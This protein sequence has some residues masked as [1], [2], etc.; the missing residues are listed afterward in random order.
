M[1]QAGIQIYLVFANETDRDQWYTK[2]KQ[3]AA[4]AAPSLPAYEEATIRKVNN[5]GVADPVESLV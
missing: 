3:V 1:A 5:I 4:N 2:L